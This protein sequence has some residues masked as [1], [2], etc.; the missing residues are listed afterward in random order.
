MSLG[1]AL[2]P[3]Q[4]QV[5]PAPGVEGDFCDSN[6]RVSVLAGPG[7]L[8]AGPL[9]LTIGRFAWF[10]GAPLDVDGT[11]Q[12]VNNFGIGAPTGFVHREQQGLIT[13]YLAS[14]G[15]LEPL[16]F[17]AT[18]FSAGSFWVRNAGA[19]Q[20]LLN[21]KAYANLQT[22]QISFAATGTP[23]TGGSATGSIAAGTGSGTGSIAGNVLTITGGVSG[24]FNPGGTISGTGVATGTQIVAQLTGTAGGVGTYSL[25]IGEQTV[26]STTISETHGVFTAASGLT[27][28]FAI[29]DL[30]TGSGISVPTHITALGT[31]VGGL[32]T[33]IVD[34]NT[35]VGSTVISA[36]STVETKWV[37]ASEGLPG[38]LVKMTSH[39]T[40]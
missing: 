9:G 24:T 10:Q 5:V 17:G 29:G 27:G 19:T 16:G 1:L 23:T 33:Y 37:A 8:V 6:P 12:V 25:N 13:L 15:M 26:T 31:G 7:G 30:L 35:V 40:G 39:L 28:V 4:I 21:Q 3:S 20:A 36:A 32:G 14:S 34:V 2:G 22:G 11:P 38:E 18:L